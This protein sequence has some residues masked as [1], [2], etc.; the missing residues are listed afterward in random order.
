MTIFITPKKAGI[1]KL[2]NNI[3]GQ[4]Y[5][6]KSINLYSRLLGHKHQKPRYYID[7]AIQ[8]YGWMNFS[9]E[10]LHIYDSRPDGL[11]LL[12][13]ETAWIDSEQTLVSKGGYNI[14]LFGNDTIGLK[15]S[16]ETKKRMSLC[17]IGNKNPNF[18]KIIPRTKESYLGKNNGRFDMTI[19]IFK[20]QTTGEIFTG[21]RYDFC[22][23]NNLPRQNI[24]ALIYGRQKTVQDWILISKST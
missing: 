8:K 21:Y 5:I 2:T 16:I 12:A 24:G 7:F 4:S 10:L 17:K 20:K 19:Y 9:I 15:R 3:T 18:G 13:L 22:K 23:Q 11:E 1:Y 6:G 14:C